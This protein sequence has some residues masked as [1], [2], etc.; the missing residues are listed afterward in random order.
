MFTRLTDKAD[1]VYHVYLDIVVSYPFDETKIQ[2]RLD[3]TATF[4][5]YETWES[6]MVYGFARC[7]TLD[8]K[9]GGHME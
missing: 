9:F 2:W 4:V 6:Y 5:E 1:D 3:T 7:C 8:S